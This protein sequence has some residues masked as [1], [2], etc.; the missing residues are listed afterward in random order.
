MAGRNLCAW[1]FPF[2]G[3]FPVRRK[4]E[5]LAVGP[6]W[7]LCHGHKRAM[8]FPPVLPA[9]LPGGLLLCL[10]ALLLLPVKLLGISICH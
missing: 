4:E 3:P 10:P 1:P 5:T 6:A 9:A 8:L 2:Y 7:Q